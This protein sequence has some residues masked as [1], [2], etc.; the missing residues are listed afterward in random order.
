MIV[1][2]YGGPGTGKSTTASGVFS[3][4][5]LHGIN[6]ELITE[7]AKDL[8]WEERFK[9]LGNQNYVT[10]KQHHKQWRLNDVDV[11]ITDSPLLLGIIYSPW[12]EPFFDYVKKLYSEFK[13]VNIFLNRVKPYNEKGRSQTLEEAKEIDLEIKYLLR[14]YDFQTFSGDEKGINQIV[15]SILFAFDKKMRYRINE[16]T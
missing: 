15:E 12:D 10:A 4:L 13:N 1:N 3:L 2:L 5:K 7:V 9:T 11:V 16:S 6:A 14:D 8:T